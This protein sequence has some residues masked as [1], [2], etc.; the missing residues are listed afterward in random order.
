M[1]AALA[2][3]WAGP[4]RAAPMTGARPMRE[5][6]I[7]DA[8]TIEALRLGKKRLSIVVASF[9][10]PSPAAAAIVVRVVGGDG[11]RTEI[12]RFGVHPPRPSRAGA[13][14][15]RFLVSLEG[16]AAL[17][18]EGKPLCLE[19]AFEASAGA[20]RGGAADVR[21]EDVDLPGAPR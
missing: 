7:E 11:S 16:N 9:Q 20:V 18:H 19:V 21:F 12:A 13:E 2:M 3:A 17:L 15:E 5:C 14:P 6:T 4:A 10:A 8:A 1:S